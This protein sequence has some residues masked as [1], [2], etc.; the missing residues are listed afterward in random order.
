[1]LFSA[2]LDCSQPMCRRVH[3]GLGVVM[4]VGI[5]WEDK[6][7]GLVPGEALPVCSPSAAHERDFQRLA[8]VVAESQV[9]R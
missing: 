5:Y 3:G 2:V 9:H 8:K 4:W 7:K 1:M 6:R